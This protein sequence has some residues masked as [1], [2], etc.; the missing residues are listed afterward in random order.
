MVER[1]DPCPCGS[2]K[3]YKKCCGKNPGV[4]PRS[5]SKVDFSIFKNDIQKV[6]GL[7][8][9]AIRKKSPG[10]ADFLEQKIKGQLDRLNQDNDHPPSKDKKK[11]EGPS[12]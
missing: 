3:K 7:F 9:E 10:H 12:S 6:T 1:N 8:S 4:K 2:S 5:Y 11:E